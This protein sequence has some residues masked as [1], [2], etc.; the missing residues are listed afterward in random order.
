MDVTEVAET[1]A[2]INTRAMTFA[3]STVIGLVGRFHLNVFN[4]N[5]LIPTNIDHYMKLIQ[6][7]SVANARWLQVGSA[8]CKCNA[9]ELQ[10]GHT[11]T[12][13]YHRHQAAHQHRQLNA[14]NVRQVQ[15][16]RMYYYRVHFKNFKFPQTKPRS[17]LK[18]F[19]PAP[20]RT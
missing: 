13:S 17:A 15:N 20:Y 19:L 6:A 16:M 11:A 2:G 12:I 3:T 1:N 10:D 18:T 7:K 9:A 4:Q 8:S 14:K 5:R